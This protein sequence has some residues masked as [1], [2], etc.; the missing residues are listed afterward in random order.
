MAVH[1]I[2]RDAAGLFISGFPIQADS[3]FVFRIDVQVNIGVSECFFHGPEQSGTDA[4]V[5]EF[6]PDGKGHQADS[7]LFPV[8]FRCSESGKFSA[9]DC[10][11]FLHIVF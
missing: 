8:P 6:R 5:S 4:S 9:G 3:I 11:E 10:R 7:M 1:I 2:R